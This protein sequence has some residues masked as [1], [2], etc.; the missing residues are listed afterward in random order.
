M[1]EKKENKSPTWKEEERQNKKLLKRERRNKTK[2][3]QTNKEK[4]NLS[5]LLIMSIKRQRLLIGLK[6]LLSIFYF[7]R[8]KKLSK[9]KIF[10]WK[11]GKIFAN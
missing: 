8:Y 11:D 3:K 5:I 1:W 10:K 7:K 4:R 2:K 9:H 6:E